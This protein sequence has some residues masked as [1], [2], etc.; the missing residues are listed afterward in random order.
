MEQ[1]SGSRYSAIGLTLHWVTAIVVLVAFVYGPGGPESRVYAASRDFD[2]Q[3][4]ETLGLVVLGLT[5]I[6]IVWRLGATT[7]AAPPSPPWMNRAAK[8]AHVALYVLLFALPVT[9]TT[10]AWLEGHPLTLLAGVRI[11][12][13]LPEAHALGAAI[14]EVHGWLGDAIMWL[15]GLHAAAA[16]VHHILL[17]DGVLVSMLPRWVGLRRPG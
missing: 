7:P 16:L 12:P 15:A 5:V 14:A 4:H 1:E 2:R 6:R 9:A 11:G 13:L 17:D 3:L 8:G 10:G